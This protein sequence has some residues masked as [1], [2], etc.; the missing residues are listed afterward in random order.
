MDNKYEFIISKIF[1]QNFPKTTQFTTKNTDLIINCENNFTENE[2]KVI[3]KF[4][5]NN[6]N[7]LVHHPHINLNDKQRCLKCYTKK[8]TNYLIIQLDMY[9]IEIRINEDGT[10]K[11]CKSL[12][13]NIHF[14]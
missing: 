14:N 12:G 11:Y 9:S 5:I 8:T 1:L 3:K 7:D 2:K 13:L 4:N 10:I 6:I